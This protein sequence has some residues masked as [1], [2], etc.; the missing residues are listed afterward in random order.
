MTGRDRFY[1]YIAGEKAD[2]VPN[3][4]I[5]IH[6]AA[7]YAGIPFG[8]FCSDYRKL[9]EANLK[10]SED[11]HFDVLNLMC[12]PYREVDDFGGEF[13][14]Y[15]DKMPRYVRP[16]LGS[17]ADIAK[18][19]PFDP[20][21]AKRSLDRLKAI[22]LAREKSAGEYV[23]YGEID[24]PLA[25][26]V[27]LRGMSDFMMDMYDEPEFVREVF[28]IVAEV[29][30]RTI[31][32]QKQAGAEMIVMGEAAASQISAVMYE[33]LVFEYDKK[34][35]D[36]IRQEG[37]IPR[38]HICGNNTHLLEFFPKLGVKIVD[39]DW[40]VDLDK[41]LSIFDQDMF[42]SGNLDPTG[43]YLTGGKWAVREKVKALLEKRDPR[44]IVSSGCEIARD[45]PPE[46]V[47]EQYLALQEYS[48]KLFDTAK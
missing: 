26:G 38:L 39:L 13:E 25:V 43:V 14:Y 16:F 3:F 34:V 20:T 15:A 42:V 36:A 27:L 40:M 30:I 33:E 7:K 19:K 37:L 21:S 18:L 9:V 6:F 4:N 5:S 28:E 12:D 10:T 48:K 11:F 29:N 44:I 46:N 2:R 1:R 8:E 31:K 22:A 35:V 32:A 47:Y 41:A 17:R 23:V 24:G 45:A